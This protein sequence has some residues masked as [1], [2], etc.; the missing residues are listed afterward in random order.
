M[1]L[2][3]WKYEAPRFDIALTY[4]DISSFVSI[5]SSDA[6]TCLDAK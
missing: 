4:M 3:A 5:L 1:V 2:D 6:I